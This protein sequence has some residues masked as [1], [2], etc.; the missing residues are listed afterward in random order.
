MPAF[1]IFRVVLGLLIA[2]LVA[3]PVLPLL[4]CAIGSGPVL[5]C[6]APSGGA[7]MLLVWLVVL[8]GYPAVLVVGGPLLFIMR[9]RG[10]LR[11]LPIALA[12][13]GIALVASGLFI[14]IEEQWSAEAV[15]HWIPLS[16]RTGVPVAGALAGLVFWAIG[17]YR[18]RALVVRKEA[19]G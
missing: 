11:P 4:W 6:A 16:L 8:C 13:S 14:L 9:R 15:M 2:P 1:A 5:A 18:N 19:A 7:V 12:G 17:V 10:Y 3:V